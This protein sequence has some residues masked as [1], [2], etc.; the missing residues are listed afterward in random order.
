MASE[1]IQGLSTDVTHIV[2]EKSGH[3]IQL[4]E[5]DVVVN[6]IREAV[7]RVRE[8]EQAPHQKHFPE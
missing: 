7:M 3:W 5:P 8:G 1:E 2:A 4:D 6:A